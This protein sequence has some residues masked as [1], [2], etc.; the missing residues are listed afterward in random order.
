MP[1]KRDTA[2]RNRHRR[3]LSKG[4]PPCA[5]CGEDIDYNADYLDPMAFQVDH[6]MPLNRGGTDTLDNVVPAHRKCNRQKS[7][8]LPMPPGAT[9]VT[10]RVWT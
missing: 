6:V 10:R 7:D 2:R 9:F 4:H 5:W 3:A 1:V 8:R